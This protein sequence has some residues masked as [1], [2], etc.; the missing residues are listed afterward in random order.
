MSPPTLQ[1]PEQPSALL[2]PAVGIRTQGE[3]LSDLRPCN[4][5]EVAMQLREGELPE[6]FTQQVWE[7]LE[8]E[9]SPMLFCPTLTWQ[10]GASV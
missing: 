10:T 2:R 5:A 7:E 6:G 1:G 9:F 8:R 4:C 3:T